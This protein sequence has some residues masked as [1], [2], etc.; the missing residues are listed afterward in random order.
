MAHADNSWRRRASAAD[1]FSVE[2]LT[3][4]ELVR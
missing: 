4:G 3:R 2:V 1:V